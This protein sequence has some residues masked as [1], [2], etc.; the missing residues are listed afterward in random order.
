MLAEVPGRAFSLPDVVL[1]KKLELVV[2]GKIL[3]PSS[4]LHFTLNLGRGI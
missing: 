1:D 4:G 3:V 2:A